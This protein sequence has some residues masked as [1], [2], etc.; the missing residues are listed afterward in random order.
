MS[1]APQRTARPAAAHLATAC[2]ALVCLAACSPRDAP[3]EPRPISQSEL[4]ALLESGS[5]PLLLDVRT[6][7]EYERSHVPG[8]IHIPHDQ[9]ASRIGEIEAQRES[10]VV[11]YCESGVR[12]AAAEAVLQSAGFSKLHH[13][14]G[15]MSAWRGARLP[16]RSGPQ[17]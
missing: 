16:T 8:A 2:A 11:V 6:A 7:A 14:E 9:I 17:P 12:A 10:D 3:A 4:R 13:L 15:D 5:A 1:P